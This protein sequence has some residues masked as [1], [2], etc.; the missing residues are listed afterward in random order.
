MPHQTYVRR[1]RKRWA[2]TQEELAELIGRTQAQ[3]SRYESGESTP[4]FETALSFQVIFGHSPRALFPGL[5]NAVEEVVMRRAARLDRALVGKRDQASQ[6]KRT[7]L[8]GMGHR[9]RGTSGAA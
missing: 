3:L 9:A 6:T 2:L 7:L 1:H 8:T 4:D 5:H